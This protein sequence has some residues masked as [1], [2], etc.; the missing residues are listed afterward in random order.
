MSFLYSFCF[1][2]IP[3]YLSSVLYIFLLC[4]FPCF[5]RSIMF[6]I[7]SSLGMGVGMV[8]FPRKYCVQCNTQHQ[9]GYM[10]LLYICTHTCCHRRS[11]S[12]DNRNHSYSLLLGNLSC[13][14]LCFP[15]KKR[16]CRTT[17]RCWLFLVVL[18]CL[19]RNKI[20]KWNKP[21]CFGLKPTLDLLHSAQLI[22]NMHFWWN[23]KT[24]ITPVKEDIK[25]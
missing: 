12:H 10:S 11:W 16:K 15:M 3:F 21:P 20:L 5:Q 14:L 13:M 25:G 8:G 9:W 24:L 17:K 6:N 23:E 19:Q 2:H 22:S 18:E 7:P 1:V 4:L